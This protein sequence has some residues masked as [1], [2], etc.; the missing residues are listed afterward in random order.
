MCHFFPDATYKIQTVTVPFWLLT[1]FQLMPNSETI[2]ALS[3]SHA[4]RIQITLSLK[5]LC[6]ASGIFRPGLSGFVF[7]E[8]GEKEVFCRLLWV[9]Q[10]LSS[11]SSPAVAISTQVGGAD[12]RIDR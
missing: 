12:F 8:H 3:F 9:L 4:Q 7:L 11:H 5:V 1:G 2:P 6:F 10:Y